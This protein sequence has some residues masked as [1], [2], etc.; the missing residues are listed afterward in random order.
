MYARANYFRLFFF[1]I[2]KSEWD[3][4]KTDNVYTIFFCEKHFSVIFKPLVCWSLRRIRIHTHRV[5]VGNVCLV[6]LEK[7]KKHFLFR[8]EITHVIFYNSVALAADYVRCVSARERFW[9]F[10]TIYKEIMCQRVQ[11]DRGLYVHHKMLYLL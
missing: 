9:Q 3:R 4:L 2:K 7:K 10:P 8:T 11:L 1:L 6:Y 5:R